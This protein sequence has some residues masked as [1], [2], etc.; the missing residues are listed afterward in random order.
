MQIR[1]RGNN[2]FGYAVVWDM[3]GGLPPS[4]EV[5][6]R[7]S[8]DFDDD[9]L[10]L[11]SHKPDQILGRT[12]SGTLRVE[13]D[14]V[15]AFFECELPNTN[16][17]SDIKELVTR[18]DIRGAS[19]GFHSEDEEMRGATRV[20]KKAKVKEISLVSLPF[21]EANKSVSLRFREIRTWKALV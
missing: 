1:S 3:E 4:R 16:L 17:A 2:V 13:T 6:L 7:D 21:Y 9:T 12:S 11:Y 20:I 14:E 15:G 18:G 8:V 5:F 19:F 10:L